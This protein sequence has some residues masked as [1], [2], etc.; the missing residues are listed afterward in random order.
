MVEYEADTKF[1]QLCIRRK[2]VSLDALHAAARAQRE[3]REKGLAPRPI[4]RI[5][6]AMGELTE[7]AAEALLQAQQALEATQRAI[8]NIL[9]D[10]AVEKAGI[11]AS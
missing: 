11:V 8:L 6:V 9:D 3:E 7:P 5:L 1:C 2:A 4:D 10:S